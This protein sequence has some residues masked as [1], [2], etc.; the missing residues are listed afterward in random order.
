M[1]HDNEQAKVKRRIQLSASDYVKSGVNRTCKCSFE[2]MVEL[3]VEKER[4]Q[5]EKADAARRKWEKS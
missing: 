3:R 4:L 5:K 2:L 1:E